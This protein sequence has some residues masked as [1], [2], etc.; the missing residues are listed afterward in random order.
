MKML[1]RT[2]RKK[3]AAMK[4][5]KNSFTDMDKTIPFDSGQQ[6]DTRLLFD[7]LV[8]SE[9]YSEFK[10]EYGGFFQDESFKNVFLKLMTSRGVDLKNAAELAGISL[11]Y[12]YQL[13]NGTRKPTRDKLIQIAV[14]LGLS[15]EELNSLLLASGKTK[16]YVKNKRDSVII[17]GLSHGFKLEE[18]NV[19]LRREE[20]LEL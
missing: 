19:L 18:L 10:D 13:A 14:K 9:V 8:S 3:K 6:D 1:M 20:L 5:K 12:A 15:I 11:A 4:K 17:Y 16:L 7:E 2:K